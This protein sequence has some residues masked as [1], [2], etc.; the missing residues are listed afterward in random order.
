M[1]FGEEEAWHAYAGGL[2]HSPYPGHIV[3]RRLAEARGFFIIARALTR[4]L[5]FTGGAVFRRTPRQ[6]YPTLRRPGV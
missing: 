4:A 6:P 3:P 5:E 2:G 1:P